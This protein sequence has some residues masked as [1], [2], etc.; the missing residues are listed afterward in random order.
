MLRDTPCD[1]CPDLIALEVGL[2]VLLLRGLYG[3]FLAIMMFSTHP[4]DIR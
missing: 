3:E 2:G 4:A 1:Q